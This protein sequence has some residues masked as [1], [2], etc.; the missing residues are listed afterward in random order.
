M[1]R[2]LLA[3]AAA[4]VAGA[5]AFAQTDVERVTEGNLVMENIPEIPA[6]VRERL[7]QYQNVRAAGFSDF[8][9]DGGVLIS[10]RF[11]ETSQVHH[12]AAP[13]GMRRQI[14]FYDEPVGGAS[15][16]P[17][18]AGEFVFAKDTG[19]D[20]YYQGYLYDPAD[21]SV[22]RFTED[23]TRNGAF[24]WSEDGAR[25]AWYRSTEGDPDWDILAAD[26]SD[27]ESRRVVHEGEGAIYPADW[28]DDGERLLFARYYS[29]THADLFALDLASGDVVEINPDADVAYR[30]AEFAPDGESVFVVTDQDSDFHRIMEIDLATGDMRQ[31]TPEHGW[32]VEA[33][34]LS[35]DGSTIAYTI[36][37]GGVEELHF[38]D[39]E[40]GAALPA[41]ELP[42]GLIGGL[43][44]DD[45]GARLGFTHTSPASPGDVWTYD[46]EAER[47]TR[48]T[49]SEVGGL[50]PETFVAPDLIRYESFDGL[51]IPAFVYRPEGEGPHP[52]IVD[53]HGGPESQERPGFNP[54]IQYWVNELG[55]A[56]IAP[57][58]RGS[59]GY[60]NQYVALD[61]GMNREDSVRDIGALLDWIAAQP[62]FDAERTAVYGGS[63]GGYMVLASL[64]HY[65]DRLAGGV[66]IVGISNFVTFLE[67]T[68]GY[69]RDLRRAEYGD[70]RDPEMRAFLEEISPSNRADEITAPLF[71]IQGANDPRVPASESE[72]ILQAVREAGNEA[73]YLLAMDEG[74]GF[75]KK[76]NRDFQREAETMFLRDILGLD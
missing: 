60:G 15:A 54:R 4:A 3:V 38:I 63:Y 33:M 34:D 18:G 11:G 47:L 69:R 72:Q 73:W 32:D 23:D 55:A 44:F 27:P 31:A 21:G 66:D 46:L 57:N 2:F 58:V 41:P 45:A 68:S 10:T 52:V 30:G 53:I 9:P 70:E 1:Q 20:E 40:T 48:W 75:A 5:P 14:T 19:G 71:I 24:V 50:E 8:A 67:N 39:A 26:P 64:V 35:P 25:V 43:Q 28:S 6:E 59:A 12:V 51:E 56:V 61:N 42:A 16:R 76:S 22:A 65:S 49:Q 7:R 17:G 37:A 13:M 29:I 74:H 62:E 36:N